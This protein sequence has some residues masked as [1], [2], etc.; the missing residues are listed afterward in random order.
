MIL[1][2]DIGGSQMR[3]ARSDEQDV[4]GEPVVVPTPAVYEEAIGEA[5]QIMATLAKSDPVTTIV[6]GIAGTLDTRTKTLHASPNMRAWIGKRIQKDLERLTGATNIVIKNDADMAALGEALFGA[7]RGYAHVA[8]MTVSTGVGGAYVINGR[9][10]ET[11]YG[12]EPGHQII[13]D[14]TGETLEEIIGGRNLEKKYNKKPKELGADMY[15]GLTRRLAVGVHNVI[16][17]WSPDVVVLGGSQMR[18][19]SVEQVHKEVVAR[20]VMFPY[21]PDVVMAEL[22]SSNGLFGALAYAKQLTEQSVKSQ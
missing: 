1:V 5:A 18:D 17:L 11:R 6:G 2:F 9:V 8:Y 7:G 12:T 16:H 21:V 3:F 19:I 4:L 13:N 10:L 15:A 22:G 20:N 14:Q